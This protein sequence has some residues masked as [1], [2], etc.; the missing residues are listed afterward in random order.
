MRGL[1][2]GCP[3]VV[4]SHSL[5]LSAKYSPRCGSMKYRLLHQ[6]STGPRVPIARSCIYRRS[7]DLWLPTY[8]IRSPLPH[9]VTCRSL[10]TPQILWDCYWTT[11]VMPNGCL[12]SS[13]HLIICTL[14]NGFERVLSVQASLFQW[15]CAASV[16]TIYLFTIFCI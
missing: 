9:W 16:S 11:T 6:D 15:L 8:D 10:L 14:F 12:S 2:T 13:D 7:L 1:L 5:E 3:S 4:I